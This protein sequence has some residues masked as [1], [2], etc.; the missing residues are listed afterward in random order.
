M[1]SCIY[2]SKHIDVN[3][4]HLPRNCRLTINKISAIF[5]CLA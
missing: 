3:V 1:V 2:D 5:M 4:F